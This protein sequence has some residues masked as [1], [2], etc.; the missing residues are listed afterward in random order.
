MLSWAPLLTVPACAVVSALVVGVF[1]R[2][3]ELEDGPLLRRFILV[4]AIGVG[5]LC[6]M[7]Q[8]P[9]VQQRLHPE[10]R[11]KADIEADSIYKALTNLGPEYAAQFLG[12]LDAERATI[13]TLPEA[14]LQARPMLTALA[15]ARLQFTDQAAHVAWGQATLDTLRE[16]QARSS[17][18][19]YAALSGQALDRE[20][21]AHGFSA[22]NSAEFES[23]ALQVLE[24]S[25]RFLS[26][27]RARG[28]SQCRPTSGLQCNDARLAG[29]PGRY[30]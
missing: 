12:V 30:H 11:L 4:L 8:R 25:G 27:T 29:D 15:T 22:Q 6:A 24:S 18:E 21:L 28:A 13:A 20:T 1:H 3:D 23:A 9:A 14:R 5:L 16:P 10:L 26:G 19:C 17:D 7:A 2:N